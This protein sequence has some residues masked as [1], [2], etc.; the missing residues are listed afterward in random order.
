[1][2]LADSIGAVVGGLLGKG[3][4]SA[5][6]LSALF[7]TIDSAGAE[8]KN[9]IDA[10]P[11]ELQQQYAAY[12]AAN[13][14]AAGTLQSTIAG[15]NADLMTQTKANFDPNSAAVKAAQDA[16][17]TAIY[18]DVPGQQAAIREALAAT[19][20][21]GRGTAAKQLAAPVLQ[22]GAKVA[23]SDLNI[24]ASQLQ[25]QQQAVQT[26][27]EKINSVDDA[28]ANTMF[29]MSKDQALQ[30]LTNGRQDLQQQLTQLINQSTTQTN[31]TLGVQGADI[32]NKYNQS[33]ADNAN[34]NNKVNGW[35]NL[36]TNVAAAA[37]GFLSALDVP[38]TESA[39]VG[40]N[41]NVAPNQYA[42]LGY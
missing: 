39:P 23:Q 22:A 8:Q 1:M 26:A 16:A 10:L 34:Y 12:K 3:P 35:V 32:T 21:F 13:S 37:P 28:T 17:K 5:P 7:K 20:G 6:D 24:S 4:V 36:G 25:Q 38:A 41:P 14:D 31:Q 2:G 29:G 9:W 40:Y 33:V 11:A 27:I 18:A 42:S 19:G 30:I 15:N